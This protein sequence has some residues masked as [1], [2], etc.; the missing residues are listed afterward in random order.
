METVGGNISYF[1]VVKHN[2]RFACLS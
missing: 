2:S 1:I